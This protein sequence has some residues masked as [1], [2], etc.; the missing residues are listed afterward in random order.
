VP[1]GPGSGTRRGGRYHHGELRAALIEASFD[2]LAESGLAAFSVAK[3][4]RR[5]GV[6][7][8]APYRH[9]PD[10]DHL[11]AAVAAQA[12]A[13]LRERFVEAAEQAGEDPVE[14]FAATAGA[15]VRFAGTRGAGFDVI[16]AAELD[17][18]HDEALADAGRR[19][20]DLLLDLARQA[21]GQGP[22]ASLTLVEHHVVAAHGYV[23]LHREGFFARR[24]EG[25]AATADRAVAES[26]TLLRG[27]REPLPPPPGAS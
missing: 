25:V 14:R 20:M 4:A 3:V 7:T 13:E 16:F 12:A 10:R 22:E 8:A 9:F 5:L 1:E 2:L 27:M 6:S 18:L 24:Y 23:A 11:V 19:L 17:K 21:T 26:R 15:Y